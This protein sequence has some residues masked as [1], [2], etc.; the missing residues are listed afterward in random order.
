MDK[1]FM[2]L[3]MILFF[4]SN[5]LLMKKQEKEKN[6]QLWKQVEVTPKEWLKNVSTGGRSFKSI[7]PQKQ[8]KQAT[9]IFGPYG[10]TWGIRNCKRSF[11]DFDNQT[12]MMFIECEFF[13]PEGSFEISNSIKISYMTTPKSYGN[14]PAKKPYLVVDDEAAKKLETNTISKALSKLGFSSD[15]FEGRFE[16]EGYEKIVDYVTETELSK[17]EIDGAI[18]LLKAATDENKIIKIW[19][20]RPTWHDNSEIFDCFQEQRQILQHL[21][22]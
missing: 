5:N 4:T 10:S 21:N 20:S 16:E 6:L 13:Y 19:N 2:L 1:N 22:Q 9:E 18:K 17:A 3:S 7:N 11:I 14:N 15:V 8:L 12:K